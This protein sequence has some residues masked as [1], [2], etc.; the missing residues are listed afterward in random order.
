MGG[1][2]PRGGGVLYAGR[3]RIK[4]PKKWAEVNEEI[5]L[6]KLFT[7]KKITEMRNLNIDANKIKY[8]GETQ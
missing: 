6:R 7:G 4:L 3:K 1:R 5:V 8:K 2:L